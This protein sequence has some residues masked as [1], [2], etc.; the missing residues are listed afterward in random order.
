MLV[1]TFLHKLH[2]E[3]AQAIHD[4]EESDVA[5]IAQVPAL[6]ALPAA[7]AQTGFATLR[8]AINRLMDVARRI[9]KERLSKGALEL[10]SAEIRVKLDQN[11]K[12]V[13]DLMPKVCREGHVHRPAC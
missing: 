4:A 2:Y 6:A 7:D 10:E 9:R 12:T 1:T 8:E 13:Q 11:H 5:L 3:L